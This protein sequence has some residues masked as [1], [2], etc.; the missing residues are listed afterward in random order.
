MQERL[1]LGDEFLRQIFELRPEPRLHALTRP[2]QLFAEGRQYGAFAATGFD[3]RH[4]E[5]IGPCSTRFQT[6][7]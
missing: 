7:R 6:C 1:D 3:E 4:A 2:D 5:K